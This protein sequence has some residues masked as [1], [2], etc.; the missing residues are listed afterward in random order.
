MET[1]DNKY[2][3]VAYELYTTGEDGVAELVEKAPAEHPFQFI[4]GM[5][6]ALDAF[7][8]Q[9]ARLAQGDKFDFVLPKADA[10]GDFVEERVLRLDREMFCINGHFDKDNIYPGNVI[11]LLNED[12][13]RLQGL[14][15]EVGAEKV[16]V[17]MNHPLAGKD[18]HFKGEV[19]EMRPATNDE[20]QGFINRMSGE[21]CGCE[22]CEGG[23]GG[24][25]K[26][27]EGGHHCGHH[28]EGDHC[29]GGGHCH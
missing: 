29:C 20:I 23:C 2:I 12:G 25:G 4:S 14:V 9:V 16:T 15:M 27:R 22:G 6:F 19:V 28:H 18:L 8:N 7:E 26:D 21:G 13:N 17:D 10:Y 1:V 11:T 5:G 24:H 3:A